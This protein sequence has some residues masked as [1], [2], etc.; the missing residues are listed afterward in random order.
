MHGARFYANLP[1]SHPVPATGGARVILESRFMVQQV[2]Q[3]RD[4]IPCMALM[5]LPLPESAMQQ[6]SAA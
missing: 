2:S 4:L 5:T 3:T 6:G 1:E